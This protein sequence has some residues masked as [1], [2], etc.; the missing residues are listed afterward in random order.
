MSTKN[1]SWRGTKALPFRIVAIEDI[2]V[3]RVKALMGGDIVSA[4]LQL[5]HRPTAQEYTSEYHNKM[6]VGQSQNKSIIEIDPK[7]IFKACLSFLPIFDFS[8]SQPSKR[9]WH[10]DFPIGIVLNGDEAI[11][12]EI[13]R[14]YCPSS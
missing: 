5:N 12:D 4:W 6:F 3:V 7:D 13:Y 1:S 10:H 14:I 11:K 2:R 9:R 8:T